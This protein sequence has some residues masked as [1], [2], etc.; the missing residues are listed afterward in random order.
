MGQNKCHW[1][2]PS[3]KNCQNVWLHGL[4]QKWQEWTRCPGNGRSGR[5]TPPGAKFSQLCNQPALKGSGSKVPGFQISIPVLRALHPLA[6]QSQN[7]DFIF[8][9]DSK[10]CRRA[11]VSES[12]RSPGKFDAP[13][14]GFWGSIC[15]DIPITLS[16][17]RG[18]RT[19]ALNRRLFLFH[20]EPYRLRTH[21]ADAICLSLWF[22]SRM[23]NIWFRN[24]EMSQLNITQAG[25]DLRSKLRIL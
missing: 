10:L 8:D 1:Y 15:R 12:W 23:E 9:W 18:G 13:S 25:E 14:I 24:H 6:Q 21:A 19:M 17:T 5:P 3:T 22:C 11:G 16:S 20:A 7:V 2:I 4:L